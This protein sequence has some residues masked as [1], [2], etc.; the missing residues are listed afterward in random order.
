MGCA[1]M[2]S[3]ESD[4]SS[5]LVSDVHASPLYF[6]I[7]HCCFG[8]SRD[9]KCKSQA[10]AWWVYLCLTRKSAQNQDLQYSF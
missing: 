6:T 1:I 5:L 10:A 7:R 4:L 2:C 3:M 8:F 9:V